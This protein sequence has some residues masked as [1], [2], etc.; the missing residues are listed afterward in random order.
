MRASSRACNNDLSSRI[1]NCNKLCALIPV[2]FKLHSN[3][4]EPLKPYDLW[5]L[6]EIF[7]DILYGNI[8][9]L[10]TEEVGHNFVLLHMVKASINV[11]MTMYIIYPNC[12]LVRT[13][14]WSKLLIFSKQLLRI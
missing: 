7:R 14:F 2:T 11:T 9:L 3:S 4:N 8:S 6:T 13:K 1:N 10:I 12:V 5:T